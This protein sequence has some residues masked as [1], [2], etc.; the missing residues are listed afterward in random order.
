MLGRNRQEGLGR[1]AIALAL[2]Q[3]LAK[4]IL[5]F[6]SE[7][8]TRKLPQEMAKSVFRS[9]IILSQ[10]MAIGKIIVVARIFGRRQRGDLRSGRGRCSRRRRLVA[11][12]P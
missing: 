6:G 3:T 4:P 8:I 9:R 11:H 1:V 5:C 12:T 10:D 2:E 7:T